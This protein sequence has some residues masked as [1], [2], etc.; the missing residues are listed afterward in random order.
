MLLYTPVNSTRPCSRALRA[1]DRRVFD[2][3]YQRSRQLTGSAFGT[4]GCAVVI[5]FDP[6]EANIASGKP[7]V[8]AP[9]CQHA[10]C[11]VW[12]E[13]NIMLKARCAC[14]VVPARVVQGVVRKHIMLKAR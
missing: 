3:Q 7:V 8:P 4:C 11:R 2:R 5:L 9:S 14:T 6:K 1:Q 10:L 12:Y 13:S